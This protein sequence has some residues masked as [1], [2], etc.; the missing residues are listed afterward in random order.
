MWY[1]V[2]A[3]GG[4]IVTLAVGL[5]LLAHWLGPLTKGLP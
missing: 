5:L 4:V 1:A 3:I 2:A